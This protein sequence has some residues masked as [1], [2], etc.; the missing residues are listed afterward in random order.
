[1]FGQAARLVMPTETAWESL[2]SDIE[3]EGVD[4]SIISKKS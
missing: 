3:F 2:I 4:V 1:M